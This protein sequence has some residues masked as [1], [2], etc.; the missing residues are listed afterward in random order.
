M[1]EHEERIVRDLYEKSVWLWMQLDEGGLLSQ[2]TPEDWSKAL[3]Q[4][5]CL[6]D[7]VAMRKT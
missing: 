2:P 4:V 5:G 7:D 3:D 1:T 6:L